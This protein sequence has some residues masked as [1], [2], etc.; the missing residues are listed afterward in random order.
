MAAL[1]PAFADLEP[2]VADWA[3]GTE[4]QRSARRW[5]CGPDDFQAFYDAMRPRMDEVLAHL[6]QYALDDMPADARDLFRLGLAFA[7][8]AHH[9]ELYGGA[10]K[11]PNSFDHSRFI[12][13]HGDVVE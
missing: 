6:D 4:D 8:M 13:T 9:V 5:A 12:A 11:V 3:L 1:P 7:E 10:T 2:F